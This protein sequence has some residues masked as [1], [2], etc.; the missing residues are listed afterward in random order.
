MDPGPR[1][2]F[3]ALLKRQRLAAGLSQEQ[4]AERAG[5]T[6]QAIGVLER[7]TR[8]APYRDTVRAL[9]R[10]LAL[11]PAEAAALEAAVARGRA[12]APPTPAPPLPALPLPPSPLVGRGREV[13]AVLALLRRADVRL[14]TLTGPGGVGKTRLALAV[15]REAAG[16]C[17]DGAVFVALAPLRDPDLVAAAIAG[18]VGVRERAGQALPAALRAALRDKDILLVLDN[19]EHV[20]AAAPLVADLLAAAPRLR[21]LVTSRARLR[22]GGEHVYP[23][24]PLPIPDP[25]QLPP[26]GDLAAVPAVALLVQR[27]TAAAPDFALDAANAAAVAAL[28]ARLDGLPLALELAAARLTV[29]SPAL[30]LRRLT[31]RLPLLTGGARD[32]PERQRT[33]RATLDWSHALLGAGEQAAFRRLAVFAGGCT[34]AAAAAVCAAGEG[35]GLPSPAGDAVDWVGVLLDQSLL[36]REDGADGEPRFMM[37]ETVREYAA[38]RL[39]QGPSGQGEETAVR[40]AHAAHYLALAEEAES[41]LA[42]PE[43]LGWAARLERE[44]DNLRAALAWAGAAR[45]A[46]TGRRLAGALWRFWAVRGPLSEG[47]RW[48]REALAGVAA[49]RGRME[50][51]ARLCG[52]GDALRARLGAGLPPADPVGCARTVTTVRA[53]LG[54]VAFAAAYERGQALPPEEAIAG[55]IGDGA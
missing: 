32:L 31:P 42:G 14:V 48:L 19:F 30:L 21:I 28:C 1:P 55:A 46:A 50:Q 25:A 4:L 18:V 36:R 15:A 41:A 11:A 6:A 35:T 53:A 34:L 8:Q 44:R 7:G 49:A 22:V 40:R 27:A 12:A 45:D 43:Q 54:D 16:R 24:P 17:P 20:V 29:L 9:A 2:T 51:A 13:A 37:L 33:L 52:T 5:L 26:L 10:A 3:G 38:E 39:A 47:R 23:V